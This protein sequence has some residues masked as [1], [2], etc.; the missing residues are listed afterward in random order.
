MVKFTFTRDIEITLLADLEKFCALYRAKVHLHCPGQ[1][2]YSKVLLF[3]MAVVFS[4]SE[5][6]YH[7]EF[8]NR[9]N[10]LFLLRTLKTDTAE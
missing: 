4:C 10:L 1:L 5:A 2:R 8:C 7:A 6:I 3:A 9:R